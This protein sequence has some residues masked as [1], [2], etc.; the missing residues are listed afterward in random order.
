MQFILPYLEAQSL[1]VAGAYAT[2]AKEVLEAITRV[3]S[4]VETRHTRKQNAV[5]E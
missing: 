1:D 2:A 4:V 3:M 5:G